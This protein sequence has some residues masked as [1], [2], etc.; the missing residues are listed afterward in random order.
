MLGSR[1]PSTEPKSG[2]FLGTFRGLVVLGSVDGRRD[3]NSHAVGQRLVLGAGSSAW[4][5]MQIV[6][7]S[8]IRASLGREIM[9]D[10][11][12]KSVAATLKSQG[13]LSL[14]RELLELGTFQ[15]AGKTQ[16]A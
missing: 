4:E 3:P 7:N 2:D 11:N 16:E 10:G 13:S 12:C 6:R 9:A 1:P 14:A 8:A 15:T 5:P